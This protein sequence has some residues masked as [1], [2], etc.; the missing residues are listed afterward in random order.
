MY[1]KKMSLLPF[2]FLFAVSAS[3]G[4]KVK[5][6]SVLT[7]TRSATTQARPLG[8]KINEKECGCI[9]DN[10]PQSPY[11]NRFLQGRPLC[12]RLNNAQLLSKLK[13]IGGFN[14]RYMAMKKEEAGK[15]SDLRGDE[16]HL[17]RTSSLIPQAQQ[18]QPLNNQD[19]EMSGSGL[20]HLQDEIE[21]L[22][23]KKERTQKRMVSLS[24]GSIVRGCWSRGSTVDATRLTRLCT[25]CAATTH[26]PATVF[27]PFINE[28][29]CGDA[30]HL[31]FGPIGRCVQRVVRFTFLRS[32]GE[33][34]RDDARSQLLGMDVNMEEWEDFE[35]DI[36]SCC[37]C[38]LFSFRGR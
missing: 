9:L 25:E 4:K 29:I 20:T 1:S 18:D 38:Q 34:V 8:T 31:C 15:F 23:T 17:P 19:A 13:H 5:P 6:L 26:L 14:T 16:Q 10:L 27:P 22:A 32:T 37:E 21:R 3:S 30:D 11:E 28:V 12:V 35:Q 33:F 2:I 7:K 36:R 24:P